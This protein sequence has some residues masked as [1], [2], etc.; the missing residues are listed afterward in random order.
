MTDGAPE[1]T[2]G[3]F[4]R[5]RTIVA[6][7]GCV[8][9][10][11]VVPTHRAAAAT[12]LN[13]AHR[14]ASAYA[15]EHTTAAYDLALALGADYLEQD[16]HVTRDGVLV[17]LHDATLDRTARG[18]PENCTGPVREKTLA[19][20]RSCDMGRWF[21]EAYPDR[22]RPEYV[23]LRIPTL[24]EVFRRYRRRAG[25]YV[26]TKALD[27]EDRIE[28]R[29]LELLRRHRLRG[30]A[31]RRWQV[32]IQS[33]SPAS[34][35]RIGALEPRLPLIQLVVG[36]PSSDA[37][38]DALDRIARYAVGVGPNA[39]FATAELFRA[40]RARCLA[41]HPYTVDEPAVMTDL[42]ARGASGIF[43]NAPDR[44][45]QVL[46]ESRTPRLPRRQIRQARR[47]HERCRGVRR[48][49]DVGIAL[50]AEDTDR[51]AESP[52]GNPVADPDSG[53]RSGRERLDGHRAFPQRQGTRGGQHAE[54][55]RRVER[56]GPH[57]AHGRQLVPRAANLPVSRKA[58]RRPRS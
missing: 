20:V 30:R 13:I 2:D 58:S 19:Q 43:T 47:E 53:Q 52:P 37:L 54:R 7:A 26:E 21:N 31:V 15:P 40:A 22:A 10:L 38:A 41:V 33:F 55:A 27:P 16:V 6:S 50:F 42:V 29:L 9:A 39:A 8:L 4:R 25:F 18:D 23:G 44:L 5:R 28:E 49:T 51:P 14:G 1:L 12:V 56:A 36:Y 57:R 32:L 17:C 11:L 48:V 46:G 35:E 45:E 3:A 34:L 24:A